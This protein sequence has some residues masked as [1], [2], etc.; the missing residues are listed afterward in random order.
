[1][2]CILGLEHHGSVYAGSDSWVGDD[3]DQYVVDN[4]KFLMYPAFT[5]A[6]AGSIRGAQII[7]MDAC[8]RKPR[9]SEDERKYLITHVVEEIKRVLTDKGFQR[10]D[11]DE[12]ELQLLILTSTK[13]RMMQ[14]DYS[15][16]RDR[17]GIMGVGSSSLAALGALRAFHHLGLEP[18]AAIRKSFEIAE[19]LH[20][21]ICGPY[22]VSKI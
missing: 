22:Y 21:G 3:Q 9:R 10:K 4:S 20:T 17:S 6:F 5:L 11:K 1:M 12:M 18:E 19:S 7:E 13:V 15:L 2:T 8:F 14:D 16:I